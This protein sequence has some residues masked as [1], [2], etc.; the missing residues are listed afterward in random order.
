MPV[1]LSILTFVCFVLCQRKASRFGTSTWLKIGGLHSCQ[2][3]L[4][5][6]MDIIVFLCLL[7]LTTHYLVIA[8]LISLDWVALTSHNLL[9][10]HF[11]VTVIPRPPKKGSWRRTR[12]A[13]R[14]WWSYPTFPLRPEWFSVTT[15]ES[16][17]PGFQT[18]PPPFGL[19]AVI[20][21]SPFCD[22]PL[23]LDW[24]G[25]VSPSPAVISLA[26]F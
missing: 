23:S 14:C 21:L 8:P 5:S 22:T 16:R 24:T 1:V 17:V 26:K 7:F 6:T 9:H 2:L 10:P 25:C 20:F 19:V 11:H 15:A 4:W 18:S 13:L 3:R 12:R